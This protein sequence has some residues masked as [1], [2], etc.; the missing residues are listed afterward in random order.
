LRAL[1]GGETTVFDESRNAFANPAANLDGERLSDFFVG[2]SF[3]NRNWVTAP[4]STT[5]LDGL[6][7]VFNARSC[8][9]CHFK[10]G[11]A[12]PPASPEE[13]PLGLLFRLGVGADPNDPDSVP[14]PVYG[15]QLQPRSI[16]GVPAE[17]DVRVT[18]IEIPGTYAD[19]TA[20]SLR[21]PVYTFVDLAF[22]PLDP[23]VQVS[24][25]IAPAVHGLGLLAAIPEETILALADEQAAAG[26]VSGRPNFVRDVRAQGESLGR[27]G[28]KANQ[29][30]L[31][32]QNAGAFLGDIGM[33]T[34]VFGEQN[35]MP[36]QSECAL[37]P[38]GGTPEIDQ[39]KLD[40]VTFYT[41]LLAVPGRRDID[42][43]EVIR[44]ES[45]FST[46][47]C[48]SCHVTTLETGE[49]DGFP[50]LSGQRIHPF[51]DLLLH[52]M[53]EGLADG[54]PDFLANGREWRTPPLWGIGMT[55]TVNRHLFLLH[56]GRARGFAEAILWHGGEGEAARERFRQSSEADRAAVLRFL[57]TL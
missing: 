13:A 33:T 39:G 52:D 44:G 4:S 27:F 41:H 32:Q 8:S 15:D 10:D 14:H 45:L 35:C 23:S 54:R 6:G 3:F 34:P 47:G 29:P 17:G 50:E 12:A 20:Y 49:V 36:A 46:M 53:G 42:D 30:T 2:N 40:F 16:P 51:T 22:G 38:N 21:Q 57:E 43:P 1:L 5:G 55:E 28:W 26:E 24:P 48:A 25:R 7:P 31:E 11:R 19:G 18:W 9:S 56:D 37:A